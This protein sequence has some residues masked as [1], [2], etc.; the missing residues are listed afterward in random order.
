MAVKRAAGAPDHTPIQRRAA[1]GITVVALLA[2]GLGV[3]AGLQLAAAASGSVSGAVHLVDGADSGVAGVEVVAIDAGGNR[4]APVATAADGSYSLDLALAADNP[5]GAGPY[6]VEFAGWPAHLRE[7]PIGPDNGTSVQFADA[8]ATDVSLGLAE[9]GP[10]AP[11]VIGNRVWL[12]MNGNGAQ[13]ADEPGIN[14]VT[15]ELLDADSGLVE[16]TVSNGAGTDAGG[17]QFTIEPE[18]A[19]TVRFD[20]STSTGLPLGIT[21]A[22]LEVTARQVG[23]GRLDSDMD[24]AAAITIAPHAAGESDHSLDAG[25]SAIPEAPVLTIDVSVAGIDGEGVA[26]Y[27]AGTPIEY[28]VVVTNEGPGALTDVI[29][30][31]AVEPTCAGGPFDLAEGE[32]RRWTCRSDPPEGAGGQVNVARASGGWQAPYGPGFGRVT[33]IED[34][35]DAEVRIPTPAIDIDIDSATVTGVS[36]DGRVEVTYTYEVS[37]AGDIDLLFGSEARFVDDACDTIVDAA[38]HT[39]AGSPYNVGDLDADGILDIEG[40]T[41]RFRCITDVDP[42]GA[43]R[44]DDGEPLGTLTNTVTVLGT[45]VESDGTRTGLSDVSKQ[46]TATVAL[47]A[48]GANDPGPVRVVEPAAIGGRI[49]HDVDG[50]GVQDTGELGVSG[51]DVDL[52][53]LDGAV[54][55]GTATDDAGSYHF[56]GIVP[57]PHQVRVHVPDGW[58]VSSADSNVA[59]DGRTPQTTLDPG[60]NDVTWDAGLHQPASLGDRV[61]LDVDADGVQDDDESG[62]V[63]VDVE[64]LDAA[65]DATVATGTTD[66]NGSYGFDGLAPGSYRVRVLTPETHRLGSGAAA[67]GRSDEIELTSG[68]ADRTVDIGLHEPAAVGSH[69][70]VDADADGFQDDGEHGLAGVLVR[71]VDADGAVVASTT[72][73]P[74]GDY[75]FEDLAPGEYRVEFVTPAG[76]EASPLDVDASDLLDSDLDPATGRTAPIVLVSGRIDLSWD[77]GFIVPTVVLSS[78]EVNTATPQLAIT[79]RT[80]YGLFGVAALLLGL[81]GSVQIMADRVRR[82]G[83]RLAL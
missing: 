55:A 2:S 11:L 35:D 54:V 64:L 83:E 57:G 20:A 44:D 15:V 9:P 10:E 39:T 7:T 36:D 13:D 16:T 24:D 18:T 37:N 21:P 59:A 60:E 74:A 5:L 79:G 38:F 58:V 34:T 32:T 49:W 75:R 30:E 27:Q 63:G 23:D 29:V 72:T 3:A 48:R 53:D 25:F 42:A 68:S 69:V 62:V 61:W 19:Y 67:D 50:D 71:L 31:A 65:T 81:G 41:W 70:W 56:D 4:T 80:L 73:D 78:P 52:L 45:P 12:D 51:V 46:D 17:W 26:W 33:T 14:G 22:D 82:R 43:D 66:E 28:A 76:M 1:S 77:A 8:N 47:A 40:E 6:R